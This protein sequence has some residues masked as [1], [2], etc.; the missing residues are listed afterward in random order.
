MRQM[1]CLRSLIAI[2]SFAAALASAPTF[3]QSPSSTSAPA[4]SGTVSS[5]AESKMEGVLVSAQKDGSPIRVTV[6]SD[7]NGHFAFPAD[8]LSPGHYA[9]SIRAI[10]Y[11]LDGPR[12]ADVAAAGG[13]VADIGLAKAQD[14]APQM[15]ST[16]WFMSI[17]GTPAQKQKLIECM[18]CHTLERIVRSTFSSD[19][20]MPILKRMANYANNTT[21]ALIQPRPTERAVVDSEV[22]KTADYLS[23]INLNGRATWPYPLKSLP[24]PTGTATRAIVTEYDMP[25]KTAAPHDVRT[26]K[27][28]N[29]WFSD[30]VEQKLGMLDPKSGAVKEYDYPVE[31]PGFPMGS[32]D[33][34]PDPDGNLWLAMMFQTGLAKFD[35]Q[36]KSFRFFPLSAEQKSDPTMQQSMVMPSHWQVD[37]K[38]W[39]ND[40]NHQSIMRLDLATGTY[41]T[42][43]PFKNMPK[44]PAHG[45]YGM[46]SDAENNLYFLDFGGGDIGKVDAKTGRPTIYPTPTPDSWPRRGMLDDKG[47]LWFAEFAVDKLGM[48]DTKSEEFKEWNVPTAHTY[49]YDVSLDKTG[50]LWSGGMASDRVL[51]FDPQTATSV[52]YLLPRPTNIR[53]IFIDNSTDPPTLWAGNNHGATIFKLEVLN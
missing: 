45:P 23:S 19:D 12:S 44:S 32:L 4:L 1:R 30:F 10:G 24:R 39:T 49:P 18:S 22:R 43:D 3:A 50:H 7:Q 46:M 40:V 47:R 37:N 2:L 9:L 28:G 13:A 8:R 21:Q 42:I 53:R 52:E 15:T 20:F 31:K 27:S 51:R 17:P 26:D 5:A 35:M 36:A 41:E 11:V 34:E 6:A 33:L 16:E 38:V 14:I 25:Q 29:I 48:F